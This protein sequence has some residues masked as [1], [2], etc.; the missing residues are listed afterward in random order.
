VTTKNNLKVC[1]PDVV[2]EWDYDANAE[3]PES[4]LP[5]SNKKAR[6]I[7][8]K[9]GFKWSA[10]IAN[11]TKGHGCPECGKRQCVES[12]KKKATEK[13]DLLLKWMGNNI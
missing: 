9:C 1:F 5:R 12:R 8:R 7:C 6:W 2:S 3:L 4:F 10:V 11:R 13:P